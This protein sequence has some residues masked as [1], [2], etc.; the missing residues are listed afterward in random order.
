MASADTSIFSFQVGGFPLDSFRVIEFIGQEAMSECYTFTIRATAF[1]VDLTY[2]TGIGNAGCLIVRGADY[3]IN[4]YGI[5]T[6]FTQ[7]PDSDGTVMLSST[8]EFTLE[9][10]IKGLSYL[11]QSRI[12]QNLTVQEIVESVLGD[13]MN[14]DTDFK[15][16]AKDEFPKREF[17]V[18]YNES[19]LDFIQRLLEEEGVYYFFNHEGDREVMIM[20]NKADSIKPL[21][22]TPTLPLMA[23][24]GMHHESEE[25]VDY[26]SRNVKYVTGRATMKD[27]NY[28]TPD[29]NVI[30]KYEMEGPGEYYHFGDHV[31][32]TD[33]AKRMAQIRTEMFAV[34]RETYKGTGVF[35]DARPGYRFKLKNADA[36]GFNGEYLITRVTHRGDMA[37]AADDGTVDQTSRPI[38]HY[39]NSFDA[40]P[41]KNPYRP[42]LM[43]P[44]PKAPG[45]LTAKVDGQKGSYAYLDE[46]GRYRMKLFF[47]RSEDK[48]GKASKAIRLAQP[49][50]GAGYGMHFPLHTETEIAV[51]FIDGDLDRPIGLGAIPNPGKGSPVKAGNKSQNVI[52]SH[53]GHS[54]TLDDK[55]GK[56][57]IHFLTSGGHGMSFD[58]S[59]GS[60]GYSVS[61]SG[62]HSMVAD[63]KGKKIDLKT[64]GGVEL[65]L[66]DAD[67]TATLDNHGNTLT[68]KQTGNL[69][70]LV[71]AGTSVSLAMDGGPG[72]I[73]ITAANI[74]K[75][76]VGS[77]SITMNTNGT[78]DIAGKI[79]NIKG[80][81]S[82]LLDGGPSATVTSTD[83]SV[84]GTGSL[85]LAGGTVTSKADTVNTVKGA[86]V[87]SDA[88]SVNTIKGPAGIM[89]N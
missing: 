34:E 63:D 2:E 16:E 28:R 22:N 27:Y 74:L 59:A 49:Y 64:T 68:M 30:G 84:K 44:K 42:Q 80:T 25:Y 51:G 1:D 10:R 67:K 72:D 83:S 89:L 81:T 29:V 23:E 87:V 12:F 41:A 48:D 46:E 56:T 58:D 66:S 21:P 6:Q 35:R 47:D 50:A 9:P 85:N 43:T 76:V 24:M 36:E 19:D 75:L 13:Y 69:V 14:K 71:T 61:T 38:P 39:T 3:E 32:T 79:I 54:V 70:N 17:T 78:I 31:K 55:E 20:G 77:S 86:M 37:Q 57:G 53:S 62:G 5:I 4:H 73:T 18:Q 40:V 88:G 33:E 60:K 11:T 7:I 65:N 15:F 45:I 82:A 52:K 8:Y 26:L